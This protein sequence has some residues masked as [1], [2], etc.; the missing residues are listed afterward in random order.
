MQRM[1]LACGAVAASALSCSAPA[2]PPPQHATDGIPIQTYRTGLAGLH[3][4]NPDVKLTIGQDPAQGS[5]PV[6]LVDYPAPTPD[7]AGRDVWC[8]AE[9]TNWSAAYAIAFQVKPDHAVRLSV[10]FLDRNHVVY[11]TWI[12]LKAG[13]WQ[14]VT[15]PIDRL[16]PN[17]YF[18]PPDARVGAPLDL[19]EVK[20]LAFAPHD[21]APGRLAISALTLLKVGAGIAFPVPHGARPD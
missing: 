16:R 20:G 3:A 19:K 5:A 13:L 10:S 9:S 7:P 21:D 12:D 18:Q 2:V 14:P 15:I 6:L 4:A 1:W 8:A 11:T 17:P